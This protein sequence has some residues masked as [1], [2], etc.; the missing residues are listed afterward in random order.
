MHWEE[1]SKGIGIVSGEIEYPWRHLLS[2]ELCVTVQSLILLFIKLIYL[3][4][5]F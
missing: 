2:P 5:I 3:T 1:R 4:S